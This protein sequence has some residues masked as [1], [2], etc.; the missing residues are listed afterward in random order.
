MLA[1]AAG[2]LTQP[3]LDARRADLANPP[4]TTHGSLLA[5]TFLR[6]LLH[7]AFS[8]NRFMQISRAPN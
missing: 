7:V 6:P 3:R 1:P 4:R 5:G 2:T 8:E